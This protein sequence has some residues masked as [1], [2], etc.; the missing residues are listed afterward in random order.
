MKQ[1][2]WAILRECQYSGQGEK[3]VLF[4]LNVFSRKI[5]LMAYFFYQTSLKSQMSL[6]LYRELNFPLPNM[7]GSWS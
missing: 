1:F 6:N 2:D 4:L 5:V 3:V 7:L